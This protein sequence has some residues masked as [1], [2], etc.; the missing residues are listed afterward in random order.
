MFRWL[1]RPPA[2]ARERVG[3]ASVEFYKLLRGMSK[4][5]ATSAAFKKGCA[6]YCDQL[7]KHFPGVRKFVEEERN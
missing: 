1:K 2:G 7:E 3:G 6:A 5:D 4:S